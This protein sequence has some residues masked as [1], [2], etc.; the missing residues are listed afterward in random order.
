ML[1]HSIES[2]I[3]ASHTE[4]AKTVSSKFRA[5]EL[6]LPDRLETFQETDRDH[7]SANPLFKAADGIVACIKKWHQKNHLL[8]DDGTDTDR[9]NTLD[10]K[11]VV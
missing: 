11:S 3:A 9:S 6:E 2:D 1:D 7:D 10:R 8:K 4:E 5:E